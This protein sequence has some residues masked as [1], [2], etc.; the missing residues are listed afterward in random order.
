MYKQ[1]VSKLKKLNKTYSIKS[2]EKLIPTVGEKQFLPLINEN[3]LNIDSY[4]IISLLLYFNLDFDEELETE[5]YKN[6][7]NNKK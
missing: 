6:K 3:F 1:L 2:L 7:I 4:Y 5:Y